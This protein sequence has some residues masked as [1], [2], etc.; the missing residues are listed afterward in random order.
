MAQLETRAF[1][2][3][4]QAYLA[5]KASLAELDQRIME[6]LEA[7]FQKETPW[8]DLALE[9]QLWVAELNQGHRD[10]AE[11]R[12]LIRAFVDRHAVVVEKT[13]QHAF[14]SNNVTSTGYTMPEGQAVALLQTVHR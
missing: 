8:D 6:H 1:V 3:R 10:E 12:E 2:E 5:G 11:I 14:G 9:I 7:F 13:E 4:V